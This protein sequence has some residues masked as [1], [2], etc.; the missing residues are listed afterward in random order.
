MNNCEFEN[1]KHLIPRL[2]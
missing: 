1:V 2:M